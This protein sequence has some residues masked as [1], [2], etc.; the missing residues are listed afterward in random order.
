MSKPNCYKCKW[1]QDLPVDCHS[2]CKHPNLIEL[3]KTIR[4]NA[5][6]RRSGWFSWPFNF[7]PVWLEA[8]GG[9]ESNKDTP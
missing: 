8:C 5:H 6:G 9:F 4:G 1:R 3:A 2:Q 7:D